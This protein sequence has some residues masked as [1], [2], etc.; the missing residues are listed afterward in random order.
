MVTQTGI[1]RKE[2][3]LA[4]VLIV[5]GIIGWIAAFALIVERIHLLTDPSDP[6]SCDFSLLVQCKANLESTQGAIF[7]F[8]NPII[9]LGAWIAPIVVGAGMLSGA[10][11]GR[12]FW[13]AFNAGVLAALVLVIWLITQSIFFLGTLCP[14]CMVTWSVTI[15]VFWAVTL[16]NLATGVIPSPARARRFFGGAYSWIIIIVIVSYL[17]VAIVAQLGLDVISRLG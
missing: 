6:L 2:T 7:G 17:A 8:P 9:G 15:P 3:L 1:A 13:L 12:W 14:W 10:R 11:F 4:I 5:A 16:R